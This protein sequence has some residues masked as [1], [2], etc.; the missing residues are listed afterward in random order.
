MADNKSLFEEMF[1]PSTGLKLL[2]PYTNSKNKHKM[3]CTICSYEF[4]ATP[5][6][7]S[8]NVKRRI[9]QNF[10]NPKGC[11]NCH[12]PDKL[13]QASSQS[14]ESDLNSINI[15]LLEKYKGS[16]VLHQV[17]C[18]KC[19][20]MWKARPATLKQSNKDYGS[21]GCPK[22]KSYKAKADAKKRNEN[23][24]HN[25]RKVPPQ[26][27][28][29]L[30]KMANEHD[31]RKR[32][33]DINIE[34]ID[35]YIGSKKHH[36][37]QCKICDHQWKTTPIAC[38]QSYRKHKTNGCPSCNNIRKEK[39]YQQKRK[40][41]FNIFNQKNI[42]ILSEDYNGNQT[43]TNKILVKNKDCNHTFYVAPGNVVHNNVICPI[44]NTERKREKYKIENQL[45]HERWAE[46]ASEWEIYKSKV[47]SLTRVNF[48][49]NQNIINPN[50]YQRGI[51]GEKDAYHLDHIF[52]VRWCFEHKVP[53]EA[54]ADISN[55][56]FLPWDDNLK[57]GR[58][59]LADI[60]PESIVPY[61]NKNDHKNAIFEIKQELN[62]KDIEFEQDC[63][64]LSPYKVDL[65][66]PKQHIAIRIYNTIDS[67]EQ[68][69]SSQKTQSNLY[70]LAKVKGIRIIQIFSDEWVN[71]R[72]LVLNKILYI[73]NCVSNVDKIYARNV[74]IKEVNTKDKNTFLDLYHIQGQDKSKINIGAYHPDNHNRLI[75]IMT[76]CS[77][78]QPLGGKKQINYN[79]WELSRF[80]TDISTRIPGIASKLLTY[81][82]RNYQWDEIYS[83]ADKR[84]S[85]GNVY[86][87][88]GFEEA[89]H[90]PPAYWYVVDGVRKHRWGFRK[91]AL[92]KNFPEFNPNLTEYENMLNWGYDRVWDCGTIKYVLK[93]N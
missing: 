26:A 92:K 41:I 15:Q 42:E 70:K 53:P 54:C 16:I 1:E 91:D 69:T 5:L 58:K 75:A 89:H 45:K 47:T 93:N 27:K 48:D 46:T 28:P 32:L 22:C 55:L 39:E 57:K 3:L 49:N 59:L 38:L 83:Y 11:R 90:N 71:N 35:N 66:I 85:T 8:Q 86:Q 62:K 78:R 17:K 87:K 56:Q 9:K 65:Y 29:S 6:S 36:L 23:K 43:T 72:I 19:N 61:Y 64:L 33:T 73:C 80:A 31:Y 84:W 82:K 24:I 4:E 81:F 10:P 30:K 7:Q 14:Y 63:P 79:S 18:I 25:T 50:N 68:F 44:C 37:L 60:I 21:N 88:I 13:S 12:K 74:I 52:P 2:E 76:F 34:L 51:A 67:T 40:R 77:P 20:H